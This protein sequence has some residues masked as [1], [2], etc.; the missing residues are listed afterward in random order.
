MPELE[1]FPKTDTVIVYPDRVQMVKVCE[2]NIST[3]NGTE[4]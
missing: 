4:G 1:I 3:G 2:I